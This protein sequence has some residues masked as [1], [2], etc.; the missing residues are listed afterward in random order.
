MKGA[1]R[2]WGNEEAGS[3]REHSGDEIEGN[4]DKET[5]SS[6]R[7]RRKVGVTES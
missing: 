5:D 4:A 1:R 6:P 3:D 7:K 2:K